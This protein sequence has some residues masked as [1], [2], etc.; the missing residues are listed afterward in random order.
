MQQKPF[1]QRIDLISRLREVLSVYAEGLSIAKE[2]IQNAD[3]ATATVFS[4]ELVLS[5]EEKDETSPFLLC[6]NDALFTEADFASICSVGASGKTGTR[7]GRYGLG[8]NSVYHLTDTPTFS[9]KRGRKKKNI[10]L[11]YG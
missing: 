1:G 9:K 7:T 8:F 6:Y 2:L 11:P 5:L 4:L 3:D 10:P